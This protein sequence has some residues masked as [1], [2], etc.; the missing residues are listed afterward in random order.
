MSSNSVSSTSS[1]TDINSAQVV[2][3]QQF[4]LSQPDEAKLSYQ[5][6][7]HQ[8][9]RLQFEAANVSSRRRSADPSKKAPGL[10]TSTSSNSSRGSVSSTSS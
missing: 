7:M 6:L 4:D 1:F 8:H 10:P 9:T 5:K 2:F 3:N